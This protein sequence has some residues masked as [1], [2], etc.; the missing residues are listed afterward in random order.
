VSALATIHG[1]DCQ[2]RGCLVHDIAQEVARTLAQAPTDAPAQG[3]FRYADAARWLGVGVTK[4][5]EWVDRGALP[6]VQMDGCVR[7]RRED[8]VAFAAGWRYRT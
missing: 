4:L 3:L 7:I 2:C 1:R 5:R 8:L 6:T